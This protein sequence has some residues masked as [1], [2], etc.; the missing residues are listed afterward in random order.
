MPD[1][2][3]P[4]ATVIKAEATS[5]EVSSIA[6]RVEEALEGEEVGPCIMAL[7]SLVMLIQR[8][9]CSPEQLQSLVRDTSEFICISLDCLDHQPIPSSDGSIFSTPTNKIN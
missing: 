9:S 5:D 1:T 4:N 8:P 2:R 7:L 6:M 3:P